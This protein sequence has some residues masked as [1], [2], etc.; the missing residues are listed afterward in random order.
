VEREVDRQVVRSVGWQ[1]TKVAVQIVQYIVLARLVLPAEYGKFALALPVFALLTAL[2]DGGLST[3]AVTGR[4]YDVRLAS[5]LCVTQLG[6]GL[7]TGIAMV[8]AAPIL[9]FVFD[10]PEL[11]SVGGWLALCLLINAWSLQP[12]AR[13]RREVRIGALA[14]VEIAGVV[15]S[16]AAAWVL[17]TRVSG[18]G[19]LIVAQVTNVA[20][21]T[22]AALLMAPVRFY[23][24]RGTDS[25]RHAV[26]I[27][28]HM[29]A[30]NVLN[31]AGN[32]LPALILGFFVLVDQVGFFNRANQLL[33]LPLFVLAPA[34]TNFLLPLLSRAVGQREQCARHVRRTLR[35]FL[36]A[37]IPA[38]V[39]IAIGPADLIAG[40]LG[41]EWRPAVPILSALSPVFIVQLV[42]VVALVTMVSAERSRTVRMYSILNL[43]VT[44]AAVIATAPFGVMAMALGLTLSGL[45][46]RAPLAVG[47]A[48]REGTLSVGD[49]REALRFT[50]LLIVVA[51]AAMWLCRALPVPAIAGQIV[52]LGIAAVISAVALLQTFRSGPEPSPA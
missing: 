33:N 12:R 22:V 40:I 10:L 32:Q 5:D 19:L 35:L 30:T 29:V 45:L 17:H 9:A 38:C 6:L 36:A 34:L 51:G 18:L 37:T 52:G 28:R 48:I 1:V 47:L 13:L 49:V 2:N 15:L 42:A 39:W 44:L 4:R 11:R 26:E 8:V 24:F 43:A 21:T 7:A 27:G 16:L 25:Y 20:V 3:A 46:V 14:L 23:R 31:S 50:L 41:D